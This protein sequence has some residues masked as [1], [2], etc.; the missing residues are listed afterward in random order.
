MVWCNEVWF[1]A[2]GFRIVSGWSVYGAAI[3]IMLAAHSK[4]LYGDEMQVDFIQ[5]DFFVVEVN[6]VA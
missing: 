4:K 1:I 2:K 6:E 3:L 5:Q